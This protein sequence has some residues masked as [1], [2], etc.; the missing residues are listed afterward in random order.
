MRGRESRDGAER[1]RGARGWRGW[2]RRGG[3]G[4]QEEGVGKRVGEGGRADIEVAQLVG[5]VT[6][7]RLLDVGK[8]GAM[9]HI[10]EAGRER[11][12]GLVRIGLR[13]SR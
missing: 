8:A 9:V 3:G 7:D 10:C 6:A 2:R 5:L 11:L 13:G 1:E 12:V 4:R